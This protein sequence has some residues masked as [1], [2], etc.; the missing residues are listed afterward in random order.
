MKS[1]L[2]DIGDSKGVIIPSHFLNECGIEKEVTIKV[3]NN[4]IIISSDNAKRKGWVDAFKE[5][6]EN[7]DDE[8]IIPDVFEDEHFN[9]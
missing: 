6:A 4:S 8:L 7:G 3:R 5:M 9:D 1:S 2:I